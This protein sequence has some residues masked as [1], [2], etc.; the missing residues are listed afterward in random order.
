MYVEFDNIH[1]LFSPEV[2]EDA[3][4]LMNDADLSYYEVYYETIS[5]G[6]LVIWGIPIPETFGETYENL[7]EVVEHEGL[8]EDYE[9]DG[10]YNIGM[11][12]ICENY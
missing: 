10:I 6:L 3:E 2:Q 5:C 12:Y 11:N 9:F 1:T 8:T 7:L 4:A